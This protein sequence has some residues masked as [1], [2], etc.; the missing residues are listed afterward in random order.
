MPCLIRHQHNCAMIK[1]LGSVASPA[2]VLSDTAGAGGR[3]S[4]SISHAPWYL[5]D[6][7]PIDLHIVCEATQAGLFVAIDDDG[8]RLAARL[9]PGATL[10]DCDFHYPAVRLDAPLPLQTV[11]IEK[12]WGAEVWYTGIEKRGVCH[13]G[14]VPLPWLMEVGGHWLTGTSER[15]PVL[16]K[17]LDP[18]PDDVYGDLYFEMHEEKIEVYVV[19]GVDKN[20]WPDGTGAIRF[21]FKEDRLKSFESV[22]AFKRAYADSVEAYRQ[23]RT[24]IDDQFDRFRQQEGLDADAVIRPQTLEAWKSKLDPALVQR[25]EELRAEMNAFTELQPLNV[26][27]VVRVQPFTPHSLQHGVRVIEFQTP[28]YE[29]YIM[30][31]AQKVLTQSHWDTVEAIERINWDATFDKAL[32]EVDSGPDYRVEMAADFSA[33]EVHRVSLSAGGEYPMAGDGTYRLVITV[34]GKVSLAGS[35]L[36]PEAAALVPASA[37]DA[38]LRAEDESCVLVATPKSGQDV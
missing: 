22:D 20:A 38:T 24:S 29:R 34:F 35:P 17:I 28:H 14:G 23:V 10:T 27:D 18:L 15:S 13:A 6:T 37:S 25:E 31:F 32:V 36:A 12:P 26:G 5:P 3:V 11:R 9:K 21:G 16:L 1:S 30:S 4:F 2:S 33:F 19:T 7:A 8:E